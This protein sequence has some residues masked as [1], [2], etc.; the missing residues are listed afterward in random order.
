[1]PISQ[2]RQC[3]SAHGEK[4]RNKT[5]Q[6]AKAQLSTLVKYRGAIWSQYR[7]YE[8]DNC[9]HWHVGHKSQYLTKRNRKNFSWSS[10]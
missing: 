5:E 3:H 7:I 9:G 6:D 2:R 4:W 8:C 1:M 10:A